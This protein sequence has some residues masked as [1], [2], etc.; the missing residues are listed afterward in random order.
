MAGRNGDFLP[1]I[2]R[3]I[4]Y[5]YGSEGIFTEMIGK[6]SPEINGMTGLRAFFV[7]AQGKNTIFT[8]LFAPQA[9]QAVRITDRRGFQIEV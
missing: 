6:Q 4:G 8:M 7:A 9:P 5:G 1:E 3:W 2:R